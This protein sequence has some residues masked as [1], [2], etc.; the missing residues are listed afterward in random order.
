MKAAAAAAGRHSAGA[1]DGGVAAQAPVY[2]RRVQLRPG[3][4]LRVRPP[5]GHGAALRRRRVLPQRHPRSGPFLLLPTLW[6]VPRP[7]A[8]AHATAARALQQ[9]GFSAES[10]LTDVSQVMSDSKHPLLSAVACSELIQKTDGINVYV[11]TRQ[12]TS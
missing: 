3:P 6:H 5:P 11:G 1:A 4:V 10:V 7:L 2:R 8:A 9:H 12:G